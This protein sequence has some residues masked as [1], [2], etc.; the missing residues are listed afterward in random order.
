M[1]AQ[2]LLIELGTEELP[3][4]SLETL[5][6]AFENN[7][8]NLLKDARL[9]HGGTQSYA[10]PRRLAVLLRDVAT[11]QPDE[12]VELLGPAVKAAFDAEGNPTQA[13]LG[14]ARKCGLSDVA[15][16]TRI[17]T[18]KGERLG[19]SEHRPGKPTAELLG[20]LIE[21]ALQGLP[22]AKRMRWGAGT[23]EF[24][25]P[26]HWLLV[27]FG[28]STPTLSVMG[29]PAGNTT[30]GHRFHSDGDL[31]IDRPA[32]YSQVLIDK[33][34]VVADPFERKQMIERQVNQVAEKAGGHAVIEPALLDEVNALVEWP[35][36]LCGRFDE[37]FLKV[38]EEALISSMGEHQKYFHVRTAEGSL[39]PL[40]VTVSNLESPQPEKVVAGNERV[41]RPRLSDA[42]FF[43]ETDLKT[44]LESG[45]EKL[46]SIVFQSELGSLADKSRRVARLGE[47]LAPACHADPANVSRAARLAKCD[48]VSEM[49]LEFDHL[50]GTMGRYYAQADGEPAEVALAMEEQYLPRHAGDELPS[51][52]TGIA[53]ALAERIDTL[54]GIFGI[55]QPPTG[56]RD[57]FA[58]RRAS[59]GVLNILV[60]R[61]ISLNLEE[62]IAH[63]YEGYQSGQLS[64]HQ[65]VLVEQ[66]RDY[67]IDRFRALFEEAGT[68][69]EVF[70][71]VRQVEQNNPLEIQRRVEAV[72]QFS[73]SDAAEALAETNKRAVNLLAKANSQ[74]LGKVEASRFEEPAEQQL[75]D[76]L[77]S[78]QGQLDKLLGSH[79]LTA[80]LESLAGLQKPLQAFF[81]SVMVMADDPVL[82][83]NRLSLLQQ[84]RQ[85]VLRVADLSE[86]GGR[87]D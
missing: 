69:V 34:H 58:L 41:I 2:D 45:F 82:R 26:V 60:Q 24:V 46:E 66:V 20:E 47:Y 56:S 19:Y 67:L 35:V 15:D 74:D 81:D 77:A 29:I 78:V 50:Q 39:M 1:S 62:V 72:H 80:A 13:A 49:V 16:L 51:S 11:Q 3:P 36:A 57:P 83:G 22:I 6:K 79:Q 84:V 5:R 23:A 17:D 86:L 12:Q 14:F 71:A 42:R 64:Q 53:L 10:T 7:L 73:S 44:P 32:D 85:Q 27:R 21:K 33:G 28:Q 18:P 4:K 48:L 38:P 87:Q 37:D 43:Y 25:R 8:V 30:R 63:A 65:E 52:P 54:T 61:D 70:R 40:F 75:A 68:P 76:A 31:T 59:I 9:G 55:G